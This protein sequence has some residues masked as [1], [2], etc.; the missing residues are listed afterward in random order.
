MAKARKRVKLKLPKP[1]YLKGKLWSRQKLTGCAR[2]VRRRPGRQ[3]HRE[4]R[5]LKRALA[6]GKH[7]M[8]DDAWNVRREMRVG[9]K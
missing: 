2:N 8:L 5:K 9:R 4:Q 6:R 1:R 3:R 7:A